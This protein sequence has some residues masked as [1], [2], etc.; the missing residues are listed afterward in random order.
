MSEITPTTFPT[1]VPNPLLADLP[2]YLKDPENYD[3]VRLAI[4]DAGATR[5][6]HGDIAEWAACKT[7]QRKAWERKEM[8]KKLGFTS[9]AQ[10]MAWHKV[11]NAMISKK[12][13]ALR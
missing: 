9:G 6:S 10:Y 4:L 1:Y 13:D 12:R 5:H 3:K 7:C 8:M 2:A 11:I